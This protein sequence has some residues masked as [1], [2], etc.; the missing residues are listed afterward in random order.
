MQKRGVMAGLVPRIQ[1][2][3]KLVGRA[4]TVK[5]ADGDWAKPV[6]AIDRAKP[7]DVIVIDVGGG[8]TAG[9]GELASNSCL[10]KGVAGGVVDGAVR[11]LDT[12]LGLYFPC[13]SRHGGPHV[14]G[15]TGA[16][17]SGSAI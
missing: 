3:T 12:N 1:H 2:G 16:G 8:P 15:A 14:G 17:E 9:W 4:I 6:E 7:G 13:F 5:T 11:G 10:V